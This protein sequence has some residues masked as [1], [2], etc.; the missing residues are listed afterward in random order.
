MIKYFSISIIALAI[1]S[2][3]GCNNNTKI[4]PS[5]DHYFSIN[6]AYE[7]TIDNLIASMDLETKVGFL[8][9]TGKFVS[10]G[11]KELAIPEF[12]YADGPNGVREELERDTWKTL[13]LTS[14]SVTFFPT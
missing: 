13:N 3:V 12:W 10:G 14:D 7:D 8:H 1:I 4:K 11:N 9:G 5:E 6:P 2:I